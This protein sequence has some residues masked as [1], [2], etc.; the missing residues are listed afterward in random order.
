MLVWLEAEVDRRNPGVDSKGG[1]VGSRPQDLDPVLHLLDRLLLP[2]V[3]LQ[4]EVVEAPRPVL[5]GPHRSHGRHHSV[6]SSSAYCISGGTI[7][8]ATLLEKI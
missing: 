2:P 5:G 6:L 1:V 7:V 4:E 3:V 8:A